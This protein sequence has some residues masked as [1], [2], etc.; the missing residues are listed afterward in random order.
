VL[1]VEG[2]HATGSSLIILQREKSGDELTTA[3]ARQGE[4]SAASCH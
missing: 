3:T 4:K 2:Q 1:T